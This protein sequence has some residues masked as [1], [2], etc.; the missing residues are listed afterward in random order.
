MRW[1]HGFFIALA[2]VWIAVG[3]AMVIA[4]AARPSWGG[5]RHG[6]VHLR[7]GDVDVLARTLFGEARGEKRAGMEAVAWVIV[8]RARRGPPRFPATISEVCKQR[9]QFTCWNATD[10]NSRLCAAV[11]ESTP[12]FLLALNVAT[13]VLG[14][15]V[16][17]PTKGAD[18]YHTIGMKTYPDWASKMQLQT[19]IGKHRFYSEQMKGG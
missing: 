16:E 10:P 14:G 19:V 1:L 13:A 7:K 15:M 2:A 4:Q 8:N 12:S 6:M 18:H 3:V 11:D 9:W 5:E 17:D